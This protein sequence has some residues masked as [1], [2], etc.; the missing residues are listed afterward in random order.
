MQ[1]FFRL[2]QKNNKKK[3]IETN[4][5]NEQMDLKQE[6]RRKN[7]GNKKNKSR[8]KTLNKH[9]EMEKLKYVEILQVWGHS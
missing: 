9:E 4:K 5:A 8:G 2:P 6:R 1:I 7:L 3:N